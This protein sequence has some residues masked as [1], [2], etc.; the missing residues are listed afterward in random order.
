V[1]CLLLKQQYVQEGAS[2]EQMLWAVKQ[3]VN[4]ATAFS[5]MFTGVAVAAIG[6]KVFKRWIYPRFLK[7]KAEKVFPCLK[8]NEE[9]PITEAQVD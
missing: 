7:E 3:V 8:K 9:L 4:V 5:V 1:V 6:W 2:E